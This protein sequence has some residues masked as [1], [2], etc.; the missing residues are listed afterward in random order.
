MKEIEELIIYRFYRNR[1]FHIS[2]KSSIQFFKGQYQLIPPNL[3]YGGHKILSGS[4]FS[5][6][7][8]FGPFSAKIFDFQSKKVA[9]WPKYFFHK[10]SNFH[11]NFMKF[12]SEVKNIISNNILVDFF[13]KKIPRHKS[14]NFLG[15][16]IFLTLTSQASGSRQFFFS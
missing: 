8:P 16:Y 2:I 5:D 6:F 7:R 4:F 1:Q 11:R 12:Y 14:K 10:T 9:S 3:E 15:S 13:K